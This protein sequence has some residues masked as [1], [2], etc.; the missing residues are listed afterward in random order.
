M[1][2]KAKRIKIENGADWAIKWG[3]EYRGFA[4][5]FWGAGKR[6]SFCKNYRVVIR[7]FENT[8]KSKT[9]GEADT[10]N[11]ATDVF[12]RFVD[13]HLDPTIKIAEDEARKASVIKTLETKRARL[14]SEIE[15]VM[16]EHMKRIEE[17][18]AE[19]AE[20]EKK[21]AAAVWL[22]KTSLVS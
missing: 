10:L 12:T 2:S 21:D 1:D 16:S 17:V 9:I 8:G 19:I 3:A 13:R 22:H 6:K 15:T 14:E 20:L 4:C 7:N 18:G 5:E 11:S